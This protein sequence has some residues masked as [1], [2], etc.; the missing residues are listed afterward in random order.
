MK[1]KIEIKSVLGKVLF[2]YEKEDNN[3]KDTLIEAV[4]RGAD[5]RGADLYGADLRGADLR[6]ANLGGADLGDADLRG[7]NLY[8]ADLRGADLY[9]AD[10]RGANLGDA[11]LGGADLGD[12]D[13]RGAN[14]YG[15]DLR[16]ADLYGA[17]LRGANLGDADL[18]GADLG[19]ADLGDAGKINSIDDILTVGP[20]GSRSAY[21]QIYR[22]DKGVYVKCGCFFG[23][24][25]EFAEKVKKTH[26]GN[27]YE[28]DYNALIEYAKIRFAKK[29]Q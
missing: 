18:G 12:A 6:G 27:K 10:L 14:L 22:T 21:T 4:K 15:A 16:G 19:D 9:G 7:A 11:D 26:A 5:L 29:Q 23:T 13:L 28:R 2:E 1:T 8:G 25:E 24:I 3:I 20:L 17:D